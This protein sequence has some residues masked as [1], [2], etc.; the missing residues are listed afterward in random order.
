MPPTNPPPPDAKQRAAKALMAFVWSSGFIVGALAVRHAPGLSLTFWRMVVAAPL[1]G[2]IALGGRATWPRD[3]RLLL[4]MVL[5]GVLLQ[6]VQFAGIY[7]ALEKGVPAG[8]PA[9]LA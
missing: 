5:V 4:E 6:G 7:L 8:V 2:A 9:L 1:M 3:R